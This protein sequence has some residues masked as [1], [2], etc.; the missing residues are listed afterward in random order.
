MKLNEAEAKI[1]EFHEKGQELQLINEALQK[2]SNDMDTASQKAR[3]DLQISVVEKSALQQQLKAAEEKFTD[4]MNKVENLQQQLN[5]KQTHNAELEQT[6]QLLVMV[7]I[8]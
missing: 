4:T 5:L 3:D 1:K 8:S 7:R 2:N 6:I